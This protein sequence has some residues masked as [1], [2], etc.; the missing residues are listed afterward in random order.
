VFG[1]E[2]AKHKIVIFSD[3]LCPYCQRSIPPLLDYVKKYPKTFAVYYYHLPLERIHPA[4]VTLTK[5]MTVATNKGNPDAIARGYSA[6]VGAK[7]GS[8]KVILEA[9]NRATGMKLELKDVLNADVS[10]HLE[11]DRE[12]ATEL[13]VNSTPTIFF[14]GKKDVSR[15]AYKHVKTVD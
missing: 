1:N 13:M 9:F 7:E 5:A 6:K 12:V 15:E 3:P 10:K 14:D 8:N 11:H 2:N 4:A